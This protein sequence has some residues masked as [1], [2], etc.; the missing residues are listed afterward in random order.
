MTLKIIT[1]TLISHTSLLLKGTSRNRTA[2]TTTT[3]RLWND[4]GNGHHQHSDGSGP[5]G[6]R[7]GR[8]NNSF[9]GITKD[10]LMVALVLKEVCSSSSSAGT[11][12]M[13][14]LND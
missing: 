13:Y 6:R 3:D 1:I 2:T 12:S 10:V 8:I 7:R 14:I 11:A 4:S 5:S 9:A